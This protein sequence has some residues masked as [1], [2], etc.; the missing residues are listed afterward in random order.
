MYEFQLRQGGR[1]P[2]RNVSVVGLGLVAVHRVPPLRVARDRER[3]RLQT[4]GPLD[5]TGHEIPERR[6]EVFEAY[7]IALRAY[8]YT[9]RHGVLNAADFGAATS[10]P[11]LFIIARRGTREPVWPTPTHQGRHIPFESVLNPDLP[12]C[13]IHDRKKP[14]VPAT[15]AGLER[16]R[17][18]LGDSKWVHGYYTNATFTPISRPLPTITTRDRFALVDATS[19]DFRTRML[20]PQELIAAQGFPPD[21]IWAGTRKSDIVRQCGNSVSPPVAAEIMRAILSA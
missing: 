13:S 21:Y 1:T 9:L 3:T 6:G 15:L 7:C 12:L 18:K 20:S 2:R 19:G 14:L 11:R 8:G 10:R 4:L 17:K 16:A 5:T